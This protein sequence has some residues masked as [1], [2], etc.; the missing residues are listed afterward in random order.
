MKLS[1]YNGLPGIFQRNLKGPFHPWYQDDPIVQEFIASP[2]Y[3]KP[4]QWPRAVREMNPPPIREFLKARPP[5]V[6][7]NAHRPWG[8]ATVLSML[9]T[10]IGVKRLACVMGQPERTIRECAVLNLEALRRKPTFLAW[11]N[12]IQLHALPWPTESKASF[13]DKVILRELAYTFGPM[14]LSAADFRKVFVL[15]VR[16]LGRYPTHETLFDHR[17]HLV[18]G[19]DEERGEQLAHV[20]RRDRPRRS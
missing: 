19:S 13:I 2:D 6:V 17:R 12:K 14:V 5:R 11:E 7:N 16:D 10:G 18:T 8:Q 3:M 4:V 1:D 20:G 9:A 15:D